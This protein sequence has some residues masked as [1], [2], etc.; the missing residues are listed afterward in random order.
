MRTVLDFLNRHEGKRVA[1]LLHQRPDGDALGSG[2]GLADALERRGWHARVVNPGPLPGYLEFLGGEG[3]IATHPE[4]EWHR[5]YDCLGI[6]DCGEEGRLDE[7]S[8]GAVGRL[9][10]FTID[11]HASSEGVGEAVWVEPE[12]SS[13]GEMVVR[14]CREAGWEVSAFAA[15]ALWTALVTD[16][17]RFSY[18]NTSV[19]ALEAAAF[20]VGR[21]ASPSAAAVHLYQSV[22]VGERKLEAAVLARMELLAGGRLATSW[23]GREDFIRAGS[24]VEGSQNLINLLRDTTGVEAAVFLYEAPGGDGVKASFRTRAPLDCLDVV[25][26][27]GG[28]GHQ[29]AAGCAL[30]MSMDEARGTIVDAA[31]RAYFQDVS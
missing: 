7:A 4:A 3:L 25:R 30:R 28:G 10:T 6:L 22:G 24:G 15:Q 1:L 13:T 12:A 17:G 9:P 18:E 16:T 20:C 2:L 14:L 5:E 8:R 26:Q 27:F 11:H 21:G 23:L 19:A 29:R 31:I